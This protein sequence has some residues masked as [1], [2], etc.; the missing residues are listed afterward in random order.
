MILVVSPIRK[1]FDKNAFFLHKS[2]ILNLFIPTSVAIPGLH[3]QQKS[4]TWN[5]RNYRHNYH[6]SL[7][8]DSRFCQRKHQMALQM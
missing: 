2:T 5:T 8:E 4:S 7:Y 3:Y 6:I 1:Y